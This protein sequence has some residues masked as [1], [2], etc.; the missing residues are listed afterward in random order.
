MTV[1]QLIAQLQALPQDKEVIL[2]DTCLDLWVKC[3]GVN[4]CFEF[5]KNSI[6]L[7]GGEVPDPFEDEDEDD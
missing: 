5:T 3:D 7:Q 4:P 1:S 6:A 2:H